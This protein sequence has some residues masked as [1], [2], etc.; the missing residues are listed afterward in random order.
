MVT[1][2]C[3]N[4]A[5]AWFTW[6]IKAQVVADIISERQ[7]RVMACEIVGEVKVISAIS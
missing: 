3:H 1:N 4:L 7:A 5:G 6:K 2:V